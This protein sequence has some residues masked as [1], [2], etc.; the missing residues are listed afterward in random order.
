Q[1]FASTVTSATSATME[2]AASATME[3]ATSAAMEAAASTAM[4][5]TRFA[6]MEAADRCMRYEPACMHA[7]SETRP[8]ARRV[9][10][11]DA[12]M[13]EAGES[14]G[15]KRRLAVELRAAREGPH[16]RRT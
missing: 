8:T 4:E 2:A 16:R 12:A 13:G 1:I 5:A 10:T 9:R 7:D 15:S 3:A 14:A 11:D 6:A